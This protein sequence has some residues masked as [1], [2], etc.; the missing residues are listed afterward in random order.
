MHCYLDFSRMRW[1]KMTAS[2]SV[3]IFLVCLT[4][5]GDNGQAAIRS[6]G[7]I[8]QSP[9]AEIISEAWSDFD[10]GRYSGL[11][12]KLERVKSIGSLEEDKDLFCQ[13]LFLQSQLAA[14]VGS[15]YEGAIRSA[16]QMLNIA[17]ESGFN[18]HQWLALRYLGRFSNRMGRTLLALQYH[19]EAMD[20][21]WT[22][23][24]EAKESISRMDLAREYF[25]AGFYDQGN[26]LIGD[27]DVI[28]QRP[29]IRLQLIKI[30]QRMRKGEIDSSIEELESI[31]K[32]RRSRSR[33]VPFTV[34]QLLAK[35]YLANNQLPEAAKLFEEILS[36][37]SVKE[38]ML[39][40]KSILGMAEVEMKQ[41]KFVSCLSRLDELSSTEKALRFQ[42]S[43]ATLKMRCLLSAGRVEAA[44]ALLG[45]LAA[46]DQQLQRE[47]MVV[48]L[49]FLARQKA[50]QKQLRKKEIVERSLATDLAAS[51]KTQALGF[52]F[53]AILIVA[54]LFAALAMCRKR[55]LNKD[56]LHQ[57]MLLEQETRL[58]DE[59]KERIQARVDELKRKQ[60]ERLQLI[61]Q[62]NIK[63]RD[64]ALGKLTGGVAHDFNNLITVV[65]N[66]NEL[67]VGRLG[68]SLSDDMHELIDC[69]NQATNS[70]SEITN[71]L[72]V[73]AKKQDL[74][75]SAIDL[76]GFFEQ[77]M[78][79]IEQSA[80]MRNRL[81]LVMDGNATIYADETQFLSALINLCANSSHA[82]LD[83]DINPEV[84][85][86]VRCV[87]WEE[88]QIETGH[89]F[90]TYSS[91][92]N[93]NSSGRIVVVSVKDN[94]AGMN[95]EELV[96]ACDPFFTTK[97]ESL[98]CQFGG[99]GLGLSVVKGFLEQSNAGLDIYSEPGSG[100]I[101][102]M[103]FA[104][105]DEKQERAVQSRI[106]HARDL[107]GTRIVLVDDNQMLLQTLSM[108]LKGM[109]CQV[110]PFSSG[111][112]AQGFLKDHHQDVD[113]LL[114]DIR[115][116]NSIDG[117]TLGKWAVKYCD[118]LQV[119][120]MTGFNEQQVASP[121][122]VIQKPFQQEQ[123]FEKLRSARS[124][125]D[126]RQSS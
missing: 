69:S 92:S 97:S 68:D 110:H 122:P 38:R 112:I 94:G 51:Q 56:L 87:S 115:M 48:D 126:T 20:L 117:I 43:I 119:V 71:R 125:V 14:N 11:Q 114:T 30:K 106:D 32:K 12:A 66:V 77:Y 44:D 37:K 40:S 80:G 64:E 9:Q 46:Y 65:R 108:M 121:Y 58:N 53:S 7:E 45:E 34:T 86:I 83:Q 100:T 111:S 76:R 93:E 49:E 96:R 88:L 35:A 84:I 98:G 123:L 24:D 85:I 15:D 18:N 2:L 22:I 39:I 70:A 78:P 63:R 4:P 31:I 99:T 103:L 50:N 27:M 124:K 79:L 72:L 75:P 52:A 62:L 25:I 54:I 116:P 26:E 47:R 91:A 57:R 120:L 60:E 1:L 29:A 41:G 6:S 28:G 81:T 33:N 19:Q 55:I 118:D 5:Q 3:F 95:E 61:N 113:V 109:G 105:H 104:Q 23:G 101:V 73:F 21:A 102:R 36:S 16:N 107:E 89:K 10:R 59:L 13:F 8:E 90:T 42:K 67:I 74:K 82:L 17:K